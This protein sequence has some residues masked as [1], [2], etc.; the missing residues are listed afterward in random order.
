MMDEGLVAYLFALAYAKAAKSGGGENLVAA[1]QTEFAGI[2]SR[3]TALE[4]ENPTGEVS[5]D[6]VANCYY[7]SYYAGD[8]IEGSLTLHGHYDYLCN[9]SFNGHKL[10]PTLSTIDKFRIPPGKTVRLSI[11]NSPE[12]IRFAS[13]SILKT[14]SGCV[15]PILFHNSTSGSTSIGDVERISMPSPSAAVSYTNNSNDNYYIAFT[16]ENTLDPTADLSQYID[17][18]HMTIT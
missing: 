10:A 7:G 16:V 13:I 5:L 15:G 6:F 12:G 9:P 4:P 18:I 2:D 14:K 3:L 17:S 1:L 11:D 8:A